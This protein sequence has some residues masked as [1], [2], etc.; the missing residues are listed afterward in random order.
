MIKSVYLDSTIAS[1]YV[2]NTRIELAFLSDVTRKWW[3]N[4]S[5]N[6]EILTSEYTFL[7]L[8]R[9]NYPHKETALDFISGITILP[10]ENEIND[11][12]EAYIKEFVMPKGDAGDAFHL[13][14]ASFHKIDFLLTWNCEH[15]ANAN[16]EQHIQITNTKL[17]LF[18]PTIT[19]PLQLIKEEV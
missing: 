17:G 7:E 16:K 2:D 19:T 5:K 12:A 11:I 8:N 13:A 9:G 1:Y 3:K 6:Y 10:V 4:E 14:C 18:T 15:L